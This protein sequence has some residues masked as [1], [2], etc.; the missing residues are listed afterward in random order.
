MI[1]DTAGIWEE[2]EEQL[3]RKVRMKEENEESKKV[4]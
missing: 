2:S 4:K 1:K 3:Q